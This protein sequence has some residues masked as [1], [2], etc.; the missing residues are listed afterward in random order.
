MAIEAA[1]RGALV[2]D[3]PDEGPPPNK[4]TRS[5][6]LPPARAQS[7]GILRRMAAT[8]VPESE[9][10]MSLASVK[11]IS[12]PDRHPCI[13][14]RQVEPDGAFAGSST[15]VNRRSVSFAVQLALD[16]RLW[17]MT[18]RALMESRTRGKLVVRHSGYLLTDP[19]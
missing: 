1:E 17:K 9:R 7:A 2:R 10:G 3:D 5:N 15:H 11:G 18:H 12:T 4:G 6:S 19:K 14:L 16:L 8:R 13:H